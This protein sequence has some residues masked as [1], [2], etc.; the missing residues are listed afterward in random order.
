M[1][2]LRSVTWV[3]VG[4]IEHDAKYGYVVEHLICQLGSIVLIFRVWI[5]SLEKYHPCIIDEQLMKPPMSFYAIHSN[6]KRDTIIWPHTFVLHCF[7]IIDLKR[8]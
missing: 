8:G 6:K 2:N 4:L 7:G 3:Y 5:R 1:V